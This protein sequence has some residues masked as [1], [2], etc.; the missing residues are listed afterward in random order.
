MIRPVRSLSVCTCLSVAMLAGGVGPAVAQT[1]N[2]TP[3]PA[4]PSVKNVFTDTITD[5]THLGS[6]ESVTWLTLGLAAA[7]MA[8]TLD[9]ST[10][11][12]LSASRGA[13]RVFAPGE[14]IGGARFQLAGAL[15][16]YGVGRLTGHA[17]MAA[18]GADLVSA[19]IV[20]QAL[21]SGI[22]MAVRRGRP[23]GTEFSFPSG[24][25]S[26]SFA[27]A[28]VVQRHFGWTAGIPAYAAASFVA[29]SRIQDKRHYLSDVA[30]GA[31]VGI[32]AGRAVTVGHGRHRFAVEPMVPNGGGIGVAFTKK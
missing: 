21:T 14:T 24:H 5:F 20:A 1:V 22:K 30:Y 13:D 3:A 11:R 9:G 4:M 18:L 27:A 26:V 10:S 15:A 2:L 19:N 17:K 6:T 7:S 8:H 23:D 25:T 32:V 29:A 12:T 16:T 31:V 28:T